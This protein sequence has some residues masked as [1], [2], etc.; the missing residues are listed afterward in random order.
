MQNFAF[1]RRSFVA[2]ARAIAPLAAPA[3]PFGFVLGVAIAESGIDRFAAG[4]S[5]ALIFAGASQLAAVELLAEQASAAVVL[6]AISFIN[7]RHLMYSAAIR[8]RFVTF[9]RWFRIVG[10]YVLLDQS[11]A[12][13]LDQ[14][15]EM[16]DRARMWHFLGSGAFLWAMWISVTT[17]GIVFGDVINP[18]WQ[19]SFAGPI[20]FGGLMVLSISDRAGVVAAAV[21]A[22]VSIVAS[23]LPQGS[24]VLV[25]I[26]CGVAAG[27]ITASS[28]TDKV[29]A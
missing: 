23:G 16:G 11:F 15:D 20:L 9:P 18:D 1:D 24:G 4:A 10:P 3:V 5:S 17:L 28:K 25:A 14:P 21:G 13:A 2:G 7:A 26:V 6:V 19:L 29:A 8:P 22:V 27:S 12:M